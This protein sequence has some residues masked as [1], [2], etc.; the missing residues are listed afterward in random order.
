MIALRLTLLFL[1]MLGAACS[2][3]LISDLLEQAETA[4]AAGDLSAAIDH[5]RVAAEHAPKN[6]FIRWRLGKSLLM[7]RKGEEAEMVIRAAEWLGAGAE[8]TLPALAQALY[9]QDKYDE[10]FRLTP[11]G[12]DATNTSILLAYKARS[13]VALDQ[14]EA[15]EDLLKQADQ[16]SPYAPEVAFAHAELSAAQND[17]DDAIDYLRRVVMVEPD[18]L[19]VLGLYG[20]IAELRGDEQEAER[21]YTQAIE[22]N[23]DFWRDRL[24][25]GQ[26]YLAQHKYTEA[27]ADAEALLA[28]APERPQAQMFAYRTIAALGQLNRAAEILQTL[29]GRQPEHVEARYELARI[30]LRRGRESSAESL[31]RA[32]HTLAPDHRPARKLLAALLMRK[33]DN[34]GAEKL[35][36][37]GEGAF[38]GDSESTRLLAVSLL[39][40]NKL[41]EAQRIARELVAEMEDAD[42]LALTEAIAT[43]G[44]TEEQAGVSS[45]TA[46]LS[47]DAIDLDGP[48]LPDSARSRS[49]A[50]AADVEAAPAARLLDQARS[51]LISGDH[52][53]AIATLESVLAEEPNNLEALQGLAAL[54]IAH[55]AGVDVESALARAFEIE[56]DNVQVLEL[57]AEHAE[58]KEDWPRYVS[59]IERILAQ[60]PARN[61]LRAGLAMHYLMRDSSPD[62][63]MQLL[64]GHEDSTSADLQAVLAETYY[65]QNRLQAAMERFHALRVI[66]PAYTASYLRLAAIY[67]VKGNMGG[68]QAMLRRMVKMAP[69]DEYANLARARLFAVDDDI[70]AAEQRLDASRLPDDDPE[71][72]RTRLLIA[73]QTDRPERFK[74]LASQLWLSEKSVSAL[75]YYTRALRESGAW[76]ESID[77]LSEWTQKHPDDVNAL[78]D[79]AAGYA[80]TAQ[81]NE[82]VRI[83][84]HL[85]KIDPNN[86]KSLNN[87]AWSLRALDPERAERLAR[88]ASEL[89]PRSPQIADT[90]VAVLAQNQRYPDAIQLASNAIRNS[91]RPSRLLLRRAELFL[92]AGQADDALSDLRS[93]DPSGMPDTAKERRM[94]LLHAL[95]N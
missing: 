16:L 17:V 68:V 8:R 18:Y 80:A 90:L 60:H 10:V 77:L 23:F 53:A 58:A 25:R 94:H 66:A 32:V 46:L 6:G 65:Q 92:I 29:I 84:E 34:A 45:M 70:A 7:V 35:L 9:L 11:E 81:H 12:L 43:I 37:P 47:I 71:V 83:L 3:D 30:E 63:A 79:L 44:T 78:A 24:H 72:I 62:R 33:G 57:S 38:F 26:L 56:P 49:V 21:Y 14:L 86:A 22:R 76:D 19:Y 48:R 13:H 64:S 51:H 39:Q 69:H 4:E 5:Y 52:S 61:D 2:N 95:R 85:V 1:V 20:Q 88:R 74:Q 15:A 28:S 54:A 82:K 87:L 50:N 59:T 75:R 93:I 55:D 73:Q 41:E 42:A 67:R 31:V 40:Q 89:D 91:V 27:L 36:R